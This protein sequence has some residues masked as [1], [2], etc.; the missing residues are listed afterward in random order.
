MKNA[1]VYKAALRISLIYTAVAALWVLFSDRLLAALIPELDQLIDEQ[2]F[3]LS[4]LE[5]D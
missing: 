5:A 2:T 3:K 4:G 1:T